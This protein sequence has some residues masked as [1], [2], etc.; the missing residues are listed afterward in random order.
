MGLK[1]DNAYEHFWTSH[2]DA[3]QQMIKTAYSG[4]RV[5]SVVASRYTPDGASDRFVA[6]Q[7]LVVL[8]RKATCRCIKGHH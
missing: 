6:D 2:P 8:E 7:Y 1:C 3:I 4:C 5:V